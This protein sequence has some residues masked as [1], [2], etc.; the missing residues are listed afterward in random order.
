RKRTIADAVYVKY[1]PDGDP[2]TLIKPKKSREFFLLG[3]GLGLYWGEGTKSNI[4]SVRL[5]NSDWRL[6]RSFITFLTNMCGVDKNDLRFSLQIFSD[7]S[8]KKALLH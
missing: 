4:S 6:S 3:L 8:P 2:F 5:G 7:T 1:N